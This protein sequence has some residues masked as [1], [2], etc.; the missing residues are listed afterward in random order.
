LTPAHHFPYDEKVAEL[1]S[2]G[3]N[4]SRNTITKKLIFHGDTAAQTIYNNF[5]VYGPK[6]L[7]TAHVLFEFGVMFLIRPLRLPDARPTK[8]E[9]KE[10]SSIG[11]EEFFMRRA[12][13]IA[14]LGM[15]ER[16]LKF[17]WTSKLSNQVRHNLAPTMV[18]TVSMLW[19]SAAKEAAL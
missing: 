3:G 2:E 18:K 10:L 17:G 5:K 1:R 13:E 8:A 19:Y 15:F 6:G 16:Y 12:R 14:V 7:L 11:I 4:E 9:L